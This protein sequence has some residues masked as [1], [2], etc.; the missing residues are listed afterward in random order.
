MDSTAYSETTISPAGYT[1]HTARRE[2]AAAVAELRT[3]Y[4]A[5]EG[6]TS[7]VTAEEQ[8]NDWEG[9]DLAEE[10]MVITAPDGSMVAN[11]DVMNRNNVLVSVYGGVRPA[12]RG[13]GLGTYLVQWG[14]AWARERMQRAPAD[15]QVVVQHYINANSSTGRALMVAL[16]Y[17]AVRGLYVMEIALDDTP[18]TPQLP[19]G[20]YVRAF[21]PGQDERATFEAVEDAFKDLWGRPA[22]NFERF[23]EMTESARRD[24]GLWFLAEDEA[25][26]EIAGVCLARIAPGSGG[27]LGPIG[28]RRSWRNRSL[29]LALLHITLAELHR[30]DV[31]T[32]S[33]S[34]DADSPTGAPRLY[35]RA[36][37]HVAQ[38]II[39]YRKELRAGKDYS[40][41][42][43]Q[44]A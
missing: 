34:V 12:H 42:G 32:A 35:T 30:R 5:D 1:A 11:A 41:Q 20:I 37:M 3:A 14:E 7:V 26:G 36:G 2:D 23:L 8:L 18:P 10:T 17:T 29:G 31:G 22:G 19:T 27:W 4:L 24:P 44:L 13:R 25:T 15:A 43:L 33:L 39:L 6:D 40:S 38:N 9:L 28:V 21:V 16:G